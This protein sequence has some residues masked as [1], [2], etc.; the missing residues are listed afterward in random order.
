[1]SIVRCKVCKVEFAWSLWTPKC[2]TPP[3]RGGVANPLEW[4]R[5]ILMIL[6]GLFLFPL[7][8]RKKRTRLKIDIDL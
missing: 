4:K 6:L 2:K 8:V 7:L 3:F 5:A 1:M